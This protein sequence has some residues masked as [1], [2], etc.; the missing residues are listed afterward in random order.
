MNY[1]EKISRYIELNLKENLTIEREICNKKQHDF[2]SKAVE[3]Y[4]PESV[5]KAGL[6]N[7]QLLLKMAEV[8]IKVTVV[9]P[10]IEVINNF[11][12][13]NK[14]N[15]L[16]DNIQ[17]IN[18][19]LNSLPVDYY[20][21]GMIVCMD[22]LD[23]QNTAAVFDEFKRAIDFEGVLVL[24]GIVL[25]ND[26]IDGIYDDLYHI[27]M[28]MHNDFYLPTDLNTVL[29]LKHFSFI[30]NEVF[31]IPVELESYKSFA[32]K[33][34][35]EFSFSKYNKADQFIE[36]NRAQLAK[37][38]EY[39]GNGAV[40]HYL[41]SLYKSEKPEKQEYEKEVEDYK[42]KTGRAGA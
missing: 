33:Y 34:G 18:G 9:E 28:P 31:N 24:G 10:S 3:I 22:Y 37:M 40:E 2:V 15:V 8:G 38:Y 14:D 11:V 29:G 23:F 42:R 19:D 35:A 21:F 12:I 27:I 26:D 17:F 30:Q 7:G 36:E 41:L 5:L 25:N 32:K 20:A 16:I 1:T 39:D 4:R 6:G 13:K